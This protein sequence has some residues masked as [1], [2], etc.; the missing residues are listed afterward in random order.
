MNTLAKIHCLLSNGMFQ[1]E[2]AVEIKISGGGVASFFMDKDL[3]LVNGSSHTGFINANV[4]KE[5][6]ENLTVLL[7][8]EA[9]EQGTRWVQV[10]RD[11]IEFA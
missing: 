9:L 5:N 1:N 2:Y 4:V 8:K 6:K 10:P 11:Q 3:V 7:P